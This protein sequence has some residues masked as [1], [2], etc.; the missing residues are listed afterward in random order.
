MDEQTSPMNKTES[1][2]EWQARIQPSKKEREAYCKAINEMAD[3]RLIAWANGPQYD[4]T[5]HRTAIRLFGYHGLTDPD[6]IR[7]LLLKEAGG[8]LA[9]GFLR[10]L[11]ADET[12]KKHHSV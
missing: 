2:E 4:D 12:E 5:G 8:A 10:V 7:E 1:L 11:R 6:D 9:A 3:E